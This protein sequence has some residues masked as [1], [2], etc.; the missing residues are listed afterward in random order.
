MNYSN[1]VNERIKKCYLLVLFLLLIIWS[2]RETID[3]VPDEKMKYDVCN[4]IL[5]HGQLPH[6]G[7]PA[8]RNP[9]WGISYG[10]TP[11]LA[12]MVSA[13]FMKVMAIFTQSVP[14][15]Y[16]AAR[17]TSVLCMTGMAYFVMKIADRVFEQWKYRWMFIISITMLPQLIF[18]G[19]YINNDAL[20]LF[21][22]AMIIYAWVLG[23]QDG[24]KITNC[25]LLSVGIGICALS[26]YNA[27]GYIL[28]S[29]FVYFI[30][31]RRQ[32]IFTEKRV[33]I[34]TRALLIAAV[35][36]AI[37]GWWFI[38]SAIIYQG[39]FLGLATTNH[40][41]QQYAESGFKPSDIANPIN[42]GE[43]ILHMLFVRSWIVSTAVSFIATFGQLDIRM[44][45][46]LYLPYCIMIV[47]GFLGLFDKKHSRRLSKLWDNK[48]A[49][50]LLEAMFWL[51]MIIPT[52]LSIY[53]SYCSDY[54][55]QGRYV[56]PIVIPFFYFLT[57]GFC[58]MI[59]K[60][61][62]QKIQTAIYFGYGV[63]YLV[64][65]VYCLELI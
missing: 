59:E 5:Q 18:L 38:R 23:V 24:W 31:A 13:C 1:K 12:Y 60:C 57:R 20:A 37:A 25:L 28:T 56:M 2:V 14:A 21:S 41:A 39:D 9:V 36:F 22:I 4:Y 48:Q 45:I 52:M 64:V 40:Y 42:T 35:A 33:R 65:P 54:Q 34:L 53:Y 8:I 50:V 26:Y 29:I 3:S 30:S 46:P 16:F 27:Y 63:F 61:K 15:L 10:F 43:S 44:P 55:P 62:N 47:V 17:F 32:N 58:A 6:G 51:N 19:S 11:I 7:D 49:A